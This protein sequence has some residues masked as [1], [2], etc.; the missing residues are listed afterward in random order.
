MKDTVSCS[1]TPTIFVVVIILS[2]LTFNPAFSTGHFQNQP[3]VISG[4]TP[5]S[6]EEEQ[7]VTIEF[8][9][10]TVSDPDN[11]YPIGFT[12]TVF[13]APGYTVNERSITPENGFSGILSVSIAVNDG[14]SNSNTFPFQ[15]TV[16]P[17][18]VDNI[19]PTITGQ[20]PLATQ[21]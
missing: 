18:P 7:P 13:P 1:D 12:M 21:Q 20:A 11:A 4:Q 15:I 14:F 5:L 2:L 17:K 8:E 9:H 19:P 3:P 10:L 6:T 16:T